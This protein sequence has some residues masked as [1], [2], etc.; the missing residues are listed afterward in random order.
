M[1]A[2]PH[3]PAARSPSSH[4]SFDSLVERLAADLVQ[5]WRAGERPLVEEYLSR[6]PELWA[7]PEAATE[8]IFE[9]ICLRQ[10]VGAPC[11]EEFL[12]RFPQWRNEVAI[13]LECQQALEARAEGPLFPA[14]GDTLGEFRLL[15]E[16][17]RGAH[18]RVFLAAQAA[19]ADR[20]V[21]LKVTPRDG[22]EHLALAR[23]QH[24][25]IMPLYSSQEDTVRNLRAMCMPYFGGATLAQL[26]K[27]LEETS[28]EQRTGQLLLDL[29]RQ[30]P[31]AGAVALPLEGPACRLLAQASYVGAVCWLGACLGDA[32]HYT[33]ERGLV[34]LDLKPS[35][36]LWAADGQPLL[37]DLHLARAPIAAGAS[38]PA[39]LGGTRTYM[40]P[41][42]QAALAAVSEGETVRVAVDG[43]ADLYS[44]G[45]LLY[46]LLAG[47]LPPPGEAARRL[48]QRN[49][50]VTPGLADVV[51]KCLAAEPRDRYPS[52]ADLTADLR[53]HLA[54]LPLRGVANRSWLE[55]WRK[56][57]RRRPYQS[58]FLGLLLTIAVATA[59]VVGYW[60]R[61]LDKAQAAL[62]E[63]QGRFQQQEYR[64]AVA[65]WKR[66]LAL[67]EDI[68]F[69]QSLALELRQHLRLAERGQA[70]RE[71]H[72]CAE[73][74]RFLCGADVL[75]PAAARVIEARCRSFWERRHDIKERLGPAP[76]AHWQQQIE[77]DLL[78]LA[79]LW[80]DLRVRLA[81]AAAADAA[82][83]EALAVLDEAE[84][85]L[86]PSCVL[87]Y[88][89][90]AQAVALDLREVA[91]AAGRQAASL[92]PRSAWEHL[93]VG[94][95]LLKAGDLDR[96]T[97][98]FD[99]ALDL[100]PRSFW[101]S[102]YKGL[103]AFRRASYQDAVL[104]FT[105][106]A[107]LAPERA[108]CWYNR[109]LAFAA[110]EQP[111]R[112]LADYDRA[113]RLEP[114]LASV[115]LSRGL[116]HYRAARHDQALA[117]FQSALDHGAAPA[118]VSYARALVYLARKDRA[119]A[120]GSLRA[121]LAQ[122]PVHREARA[123]LGTLQGRP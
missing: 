55:R 1:T 61:Q 103:A 99:R 100:E 112:A 24:T 23:L 22:H 11:G 10:E 111:D 13:L 96:A 118:A 84:Q 102:N 65:I 80:T 87:C 67:A 5:R 88:E 63:G 69:G 75:P 82:R 56:W 108:W 71:L 70:A 97:A 48:R 51:G 95:A 117:D 110:L 64:A 57:R 35:N 6:H 58:A 73:R 36:V 40:A 93:T 107:A 38:A 83:R 121:A 81:P 45:L 113:L 46:E 15:A 27:W 9:E 122:D 7:Q 20:P 68:P 86:G 123:L 109:G 16:L 26:L 18:G 44:L 94:R 98:L 78:D 72:R 37:L 116:L 41:E 76:D 3:V 32:L 105:A 77:T 85:L 29:L 60:T 115:A 43:R 33:H 52:A 42:H 62:A 2:S 31:A 12:S 50:R 30:P 19:L 66:G 25:H 74:V 119:S 21:V 34:H 89:R 4:C 59:L 104:A 106:C 79:V 90:Q 92:P 28:P 14:V 39:W 54:D 49:R 120:L 47:D 101:A 91:A 114:S 17:G 53:R 8:L